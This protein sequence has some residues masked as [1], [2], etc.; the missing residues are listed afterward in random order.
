MRL[1]PLLPLEGAQRFGA[2]VGLLASWLPGRR[3]KRLREHLALAF[4]EKSQSE[5]DALGRQAWIS[6]AMLA[7]EGLWVS[8]WKPEDASRLVVDTPEPWERSLAMAR[9][10]G[11]GLVIFAAHMGP[12]EVLAR[13]FP[14]ALGFP[15]ACIAAEP[16]DLIVEELSKLIRQS[17][18]LNLIYRG[19]AATASM[20]HL[21]NGGA[22]MMLVDHNIKGRG[23]LVPFFGHPAH[24]TLAPARLALQSGAVANTFF[25]VRDGWGKFRLFC[26]EPMVLP[27]LPRDPESRFRVEAELAAEYTRRIEQAI[28]AHPEQYLW[29]HRRWEERSDSLPYPS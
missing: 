7:S 4:P 16:K 13:W 22:L 26:G 25:C 9:A 12:L 5:R 1:I 2:A 20:R 18:G 29:M 17:G 10:S 19:E 6:M 11:K 28:R 21:R 23:V 24:T 15:V 14:T 3:K 8:A 27:T